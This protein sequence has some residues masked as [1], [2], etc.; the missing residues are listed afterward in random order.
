MTLN[1]PPLSDQTIP[2]KDS[3]VSKVTPV[4]DASVG[5][6]RGVDDKILVDS[7]SKE[8]E[9]CP[10]TTGMD[11]VKTLIWKLNFK[12]LDRFSVKCRKAQTK[13]VTYQL[14]FSANLKPKYM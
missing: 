13:P 8:A 2:D 11:Q 12:R 4:R 5:L 6:Q 10:E 3:Y 9:P 7:A 1:E 14:D